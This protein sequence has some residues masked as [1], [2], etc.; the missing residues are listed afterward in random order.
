MTDWNACPAVERDFRKISGDWAF[1][2]TRV[3]AYALFEDLE[4]GA[5]AKKFLQ[6]Y[7]EAN[8]WQVTAVFKHVAECLR[9]VARA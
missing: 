8:E 4:N 7:R 3:P 1:A 6:W 9:T 2:G 5:A